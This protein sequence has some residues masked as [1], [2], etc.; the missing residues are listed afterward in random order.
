MSQHRGF[1]LIE[2]LVVIAIIAILASLLLPAL[3]K[4]KAKA[5]AVVCMNNCKQL[6]IGWNLYASDNADVLAPN[7][8]PYHSTQFWSDDGKRVA[9][10]A[11][12]MWNALDATG[13]SG[14]GVLINPHGTL[15]APYLQ[16]FALYKC[17]GDKM[18]FTGTSKPTVRSYS[19]NSAVGTLWYSSTKFGGTDGPP[20]G[21][22]AGGW[23]P[24]SY[25]VPQHLY[26]TYGKMTSFTSPGPSSTFVFMEENSMTI[27]DCNLAIPAVRNT[28]TTTGVLVDYPGSYH[29]HATGMSFADGHA[30]IHRFLDART[31]TPVLGG[32][33]QP[34]NPPNPD[35]DYLASI[36]S[37]HQ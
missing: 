17:P 30:I 23:L 36:T 29:N 1:T 13:I 2:L 3:S 35:T 15:L 33:A 16:N 37:A 19:M 9:W 26:L 34:Q 7:D 10:V 6:M 14:T 20:G 5:Q 11:G 4:A 28:A 18:N 22:V 31:Y 25:T 24:G 21:A 12:T 32:A 27:N 8:Y